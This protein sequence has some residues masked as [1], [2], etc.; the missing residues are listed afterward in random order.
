MKKILTGVMIFAMVLCMASCAG[1]AGNDAPVSEKPVNVYV[2]TGPTGIG[3]VNLWSSSQAGET[4]IKYNFTA[5]AAPDEIV[6]KLSSGEADV[7][8]ISTNLAAK[9]YQKT[10]GGIKILAVNTLGVLSVLDNTNAQITSLS[11]LAGRKIV[12]TGLGA[13]PQYIIEYLLRQNGIDPSK[14]VTIDYKAEGSELLAVWAQ[15]PDSVIIAPSPVS[16]SILMKFEGS[17]KV[18]DLT[19]EWDKCSDGSALM[20][21]CIV[22]RTEFCSEYSALVDGFIKDYESSINAAEED[23]K[24]T[25]ELCEQYGIVAKAAIAVKALPDCHICCIRGQEMKDG[26][27]GYFKVLYDADP[28]SVG[29]LPDEGF[30]Y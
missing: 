27:V 3:A 15:E 8:A 14:D 12:T 6:A 16:T 25:G 26:L 29:A 17:R 21:G 10:N 22:A 1:N 2:L 18:L 28:S 13:N 11:D 9:L 23:P 24:K 4:E 7:A 5:A 30:W 19:Q 20:M